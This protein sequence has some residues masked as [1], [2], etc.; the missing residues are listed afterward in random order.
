MELDLERLRRIHRW[1]WLAGRPAPPRPLHHQLLLN[2][3]IFVTEQMDTH[4]I[5]TTGRI[6]LKPLPRFL[7]EPRFWEDYLSCKQGSC[8]C[9]SQTI[10]L[11]R[12]VPPPCKRQSLFRCAHGFL[13][14]Y[15]ALIQHESDFHIAK[16]KFL[17]PKE[18]SWPAWQLFVERL[19][20]EHI[21]SKID[22]R[23]VYGELRLSRLNKIYTVLQWSFL[24]GY[25]VRWQQYGTYFQDNLA[26]LT[27]AV[28]YVAIALSAMQVGLATDYLAASDFF[29]AV[30]SGFAI[31][32][33]LGPPVTIAVIGLIVCAAFLKNMVVTIAYWKRRHRHIGYIA[34]CL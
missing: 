30:S 34:E 24:R 16:D 19:G 13:F 22:Q 6:F 1:L 21:Y 31:F 20:L 14:S 28:I 18:V 7:L 2:R 12:G 8:P 27:S 33:L 3:A 5:W 17:L 32:S 25:M 10:D 26:W 15:T 9:S 23:F 29:Q 11:K 4:L